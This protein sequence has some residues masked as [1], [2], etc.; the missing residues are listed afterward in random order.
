MPHRIEVTGF[1]FTPIQSFVPATQ[2]NTYAGQDPNNPTKAVYE[3][4]D[5]NF[6]QSYGKERFIML[7]NGG[8]SENSNS[9]KASP[10]PKI[11]NDNYGNLDGSETGGKTYIPPSS[12]NAANKKSTQPT[13]P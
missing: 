4:V 11:L 7:S 13:T 10:L 8:D 3:G 1:K 9:T 6:V 5:G 12:N 2:Q